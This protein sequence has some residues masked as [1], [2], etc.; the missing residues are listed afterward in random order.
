MRSKIID[1]RG[2]H[3]LPSLIDAHAHLGN[4]M[5]G[6]AGPIVPPEYVFKLWMAD[7]ITTVREVGVIM[8]LGGCP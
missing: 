2:M 3:V 6:L 1:G 5:Q 8:G 7:G 4:P